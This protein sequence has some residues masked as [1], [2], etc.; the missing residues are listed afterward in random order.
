LQGL[1]HIKQ[2]AHLKPASLD[3]KLHQRLKTTMQKATQ[4]TD[5]VRLGR[6]CDLPAFWPLIW[7]TWVVVGEAEVVHV[8]VVLS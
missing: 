5:K 2:T 6:V 7:G 1:S 3:S 4:K 8:H